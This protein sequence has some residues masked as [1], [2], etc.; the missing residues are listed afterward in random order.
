M[1]DL[2]VCGMGVDIVEVDRIQNLVDRWEGRFLDRVFCPEELDYCLSSRNRYERLAGR[3]AAK[4]AIIKAIGRWVPW[5][6]I[7]VLPDD[8]G[9]PLVYFSP[10]PAVDG[11]EGSGFHVS[12]SHTENYATA[13]ALC[14]GRRAT[15]GRE[16]SG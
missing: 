12:I 16:A 7:A 14:V 13:T 10:S 15:N 3:F 11:L 6:S 5:K 2:N 8:K 1:N 4:E 9:K